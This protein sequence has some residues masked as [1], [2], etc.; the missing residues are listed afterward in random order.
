MTRSKMRHY[1]RIIILFA[2]LT[3][4]LSVPVYI[5]YKGHGHSDVLYHYIFRD[6]N[7]NKFRCAVFLLENM[8]YHTS[9]HG[10][11][12]LSAEQKLVKYRTDSIYLSL[13]N[14]YGRDSIP[15]DT[16]IYKVRRT[17]I[18]WAKEHLT[19]QKLEEIE[20][21]A[22]DNK[23]I[24]SDFIIRQ[25]DEAF[26]IWNKSPFTKDISLKEFEE[27]ILPYCCIPAYGRLQT[28]KQLQALMPV[29]KGL[30][31]ETDLRNIVHRYHKTIS[32]LRDINGTMDDKATKGI[33]S[34]YSRDEGC[35]DIAHYGCMLLRAY[36][37]PTVVDHV[38]GFR[39]LPDR[40]YFCCLYNAAEKKWQGFNAEGSLPG[41]SDFLGTP[42]LNIYRDMYAAQK[43]SPY[44]L[45]GKNE[46]VPPY[47]GS[48]CLKDVSELYMP[49]C[50][51]TL[52]FHNKTDNHLAYLAAFSSNAEEG[53]LAT[54][55]GVIDKKSHTVTFNKALLDILYFPVYYEDN[56]AVSFGKPFYLRKD[57]GKIN[58]HY[59]PIN[60][61]GKENSALLLRKYPLKQ[62]MQEQA[63]KMI[64][65]VF[66]GSNDS[67]FTKADTLLVLKTAPTQYIKE[68]HFS[69]TG[70]Y[71]YY[72]LQPPKDYP[73]SIIS[74]LEWLVK[75]NGYDDVLP[76]TR[77]AITSPQTKGKVST[78]ARFVK[79]RDA[80]IREMEKQPQYDGNP[81]TSAGGRKNI[82]LTLK[83]P[84]RVE[85]VR[86]MAV[87]ENNVINAGDQYLLLFWD[88]KQWAT[89]G[90]KTAEYEYL[91]FDN[92][93]A[94]RLYWLRDITKGQEELPFLLTP[95]GQQ[96]FIYPD[97]IKN[98]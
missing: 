6:F 58:R 56:H 8:Q 12:C 86:L 70:N 90:E 64:G 75:R 17:S 72:R 81:L 76:S 1:R 5:H 53:M 52:P 82:T 71:R 22:P 28:P 50:K 95:S 66:L 34:L 87:H 44:F 31:G 89:C 45:R 21:L 35:L 15:I 39:Q 77:T 59:L 78:D 98:R 94:N 37:V 42:V 30:D 68:Y 36:G 54:T 97:V 79:L 32:D 18:E 92:I 60:G 27:S 51:V 48:P 65:T 16:I 19:S 14:T 67:N 73:H 33:M 62:S 74:H 91:L 83:N 57:N 26:E 46:Y 9:V 20:S 55:W 38:V 4:I 93:P 13:A 84:Q 2:I 49:V 11:E 3:A 61:N 80:K 10:Q 25:I 69:R 85:A 29:L 96:R 63:E 40:H 7:I 43:E 41:D 24:T 88:G 23:T 47:L